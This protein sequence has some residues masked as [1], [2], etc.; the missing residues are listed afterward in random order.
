MS[1]SSVHDFKLAEVVDDD[2]NFQWG[3]D[4]KEG[5][6]CCRSTVNRTSSSA[7]P[8]TGS[9]LVSYPEGDEA[10]QRVSVFR[11]DPGTGERLGLLATATVGDDGWVNLPE[12][13]IVRAGEAFLA[14]T[15]RSSSYHSWEVLATGT[16]K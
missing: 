2:L 5:K 10:G 14:V 11:I 1:P 15:E 12:L 4:D 16:A 8:T 9:F 13:I 7:S 6:Q 3:W